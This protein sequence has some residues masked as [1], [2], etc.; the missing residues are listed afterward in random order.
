MCVVSLY[1][2]VVSLI[3]FLLYAFDK[4][5]ARCGWRRISERALLVAAAIG[6]SFGA[7]VAMV[8]VRHK[9]RHLKFR[10]TLPILVVAHTLL[11]LFV[12]FG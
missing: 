1:F 10:I 9:S 3:T 7:L 11:L 12:A 4:L 5:A 8:V 6:G 2:G